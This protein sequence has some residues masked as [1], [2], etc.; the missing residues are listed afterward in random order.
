LPTRMHIETVWVDV[1]ESA[2]EAYEA[3][4]LSACETVGLFRDH[5]TGSWRVEGVKK[6]G[7]SES[8]L[9]AGL[10]LAL[11]LS[12]VDAPL[13]RTPTEAS[14]W[15]ARSYASFPEQLIG[16]RFSVRGTHLE[17]A[18]PST[19]LVLRLDAGLAFGSGEHGS[20]QGCL[21]ALERVAWR[22]P[23][24]ILDLGT[25]SGILAMAA[26]RLLHRRIL[27][28]DVD[29]WA[30]HVARQNAALND[31]G[32]LVVV[33]LADGWR[34]R[35]VRAGGP[36]DLVLANILAR[37]LVRM[38]RDLG[39]QLA[40][41]GTAILSGLLRNQVRCVLNAHLACGLRLEATLFSGPWATLILRQRRRPGRCRQL[42]R[43]YSPAHAHTR[44]R[45]SDQTRAAG[46]SAIV[47][48]RRVRDPSALPAQP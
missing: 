21:R 26:A 22:R 14:D 32:Q 8:D 38:A 45:T 17:D 10:A 40:P 15:L 4:L 9:A 34:P 30:V 13:C 47:R 33:R 28:T 20:T 1:P 42:S 43:R 18:S 27:A 12:G 25:G 37:P 39:L 35:W 36:Y 44:R 16:E 7:A 19:R 23:R 31:L 46:R 6:V 48:Y 29:A 3:A 11:K 24:R 5:A 2:V 41:N